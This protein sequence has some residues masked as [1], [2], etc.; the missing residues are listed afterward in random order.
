M[1]KN[2]NLVK[3]EL[4]LL[5]R[6]HSFVPALVHHGNAVLLKKTN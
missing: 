2:L 4:K 1:V 6:V 5:A 3:K